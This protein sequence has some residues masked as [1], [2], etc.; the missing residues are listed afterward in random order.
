MEA[1]VGLY[2]VEGDVPPV[3]GGGGGEDGDPVPGPVEE[4][5]VADPLEVLEDGL[6]GEDP[7]PH[8]RRGE[9]GHADVGAHVHHEALQPLGLPLLEQVL[10]GEGDVGAAEGLPL[11]HA[12]DVLVGPLREAPEVGERVQKGP[13]HA[14]HHAREDR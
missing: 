9:G 4:E 5:A 13:A 2:L 3:V 7:E 12:G 6:E 1:R 10:D 11:E 8:G 14:L